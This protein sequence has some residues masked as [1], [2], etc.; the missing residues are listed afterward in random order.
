MMRNKL[1]LLLLCIFV[2]GILAACEQPP[3]EVTGMVKYADGRPASVKIRFFDSA[4][5]QTAEATSTPDGVYYTGKVLPPGDYTVKCF[6]G[7]EQLGTE[8]TVS[9]DA[10]GSKVLNITL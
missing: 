3:A 6:K 9:V 8:Q 10:D 4:G 5:K 7:E 2:V 1:G